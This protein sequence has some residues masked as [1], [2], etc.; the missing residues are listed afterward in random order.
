V[1]SEEAL[2]TC[3]CHL[4]SNLSPRYRYFKKESWRG[5]FTWTLG[6]KREERE[7]HLVFRRENGGIDEDG[8]Y[9]MK[10]IVEFSPVYF[11]PAIMGTIQMVTDAKCGMFLGFHGPRCYRSFWPGCCGAGCM[12]SEDSILDWEPLPEW[13][14]S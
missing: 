7:F 6:Q 11:N 4:N 14:L 8:N 9:K 12:S 13:I 1:V 2:G 3:P 10:G 5:D